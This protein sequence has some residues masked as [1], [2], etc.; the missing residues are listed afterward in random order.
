MNTKIFIIVN[1][2][3]ESLPNKN[4]ATIHFPLFLDSLFGIQFTFFTFDLLIVA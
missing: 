2:E 3:E 4:W 1:I